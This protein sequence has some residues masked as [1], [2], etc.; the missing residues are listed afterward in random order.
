MAASVIHF[1][2]DR[3]CVQN[4]FR[5]APE[6]V[7]SVRIP[8]IGQRKDWAK[9]QPYN[10]NNKV[11][12]EREP[13]C[14]AFAVPTSFSPGGC[15]GE[16]LHRLTHSRLITKRR[17]NPTKIHSMAEQHRPNRT[18]NFHFVRPQQRSVTTRSRIA[19]NRAILYA[20]LCILKPFGRRF[21]SAT[22]LRPMTKR[23]LLSIYLQAKSIKMAVLVMFPTPRRQHPTTPVQKAIKSKKNE[24]MNRAIIA[25]PISRRPTKKKRK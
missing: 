9:P 20:P 16:Y 12:I 4:N 23:E 6:S 14:K 17:W 25:R 1:P 10:N 2:A 13:N 18:S 19:L 21:V 22:T 7:R 5:K 11:H 15:S 24:M 8:S 3:E